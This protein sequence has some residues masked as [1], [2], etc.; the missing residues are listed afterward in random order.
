MRPMVLIAMLVLAVLSAPV[1]AGEPR[2]SG[3]AVPEA[4]GYRLATL[5]KGL[6]HPWGM[7]W[8]PDGRML[9][10][11]RPGRLRLARDGALQPRP[12][13]GVPAVFASGQGGLLDVAVHPRFALNRFVYLTYAHGEADANRTR[14][15]RGVFDEDRLSDVR[16]L[17][18]VKESK[19]EAQH[20]GSR[21]AWLPDGTLLMSI[22][23]GGNPP[24]RLDGALIRL[25]AQNP[26]SHLGKIIR[27]NDD[28]TIP[29]DN[30]F[31]ARPDA[32]P[33]VWS[34]GHRN[35]QGMAFD[36]IRRQ[37]WASEHGSRG[38]DE[39]NVVV[40]GGNFG[41]PVVTYSREYATD[42][43]ISPDRTR[44]GMVDPRLVWIPSIAP[45]GLAVHTGERFPAWRGDLFAGGLVSLDVRRIDLDADGNVLGEESLAVGDRVRDV[46]QG[47]DGY[48]YVLTDEDNGRLIRIEP[49]P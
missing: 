12:L 2:I 16:V 13:S 23:D 41:W 5:I 34:Y 44:P 8:L 35:I 14:L 45:S 31:L 27:L 28:G 46:R 33:A 38:G 42:R 3:G 37:V 22:G 17:F 24:I 43:E 40:A 18:S 36:P 26:K 20:F 1:F 19:T 10:T 29:E 21:L 7:A 25:Q 48:L 30:P 9:I 32:D 15:A 6:E 11:E 49:A 47:P 4:Q 39:V